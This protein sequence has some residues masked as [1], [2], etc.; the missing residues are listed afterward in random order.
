MSEDF[1]FLHHWYPVIPLTDLK[2][3]YPKS[4]TILGRKLVIW[5][6][7]LSPTFK[8][9]L[10]Q[11]P[12][13]LA[14]LSEGRIDEKTGQLMCSYHGWQFNENG[15]CTHIPQSDNRDLLNKNKDYYCA[16]ALPT[17]E[18][19]DLLWVWLDQHT[20]SLAEKTPLPVSESIDLEKGFVLTTFIREIAYDWSIL[21]ENIADPSHVPFAHHGVQ[22]KRD[23]AKPIKIDLPMVQPDLIIA[24]ITEGFPSKFIFQPPCRL[25]YDITF[26]SGKKAGVVLYCIPVLP[27]KSRVVAIVYRNFAQSLHRFTPRWW[28]HHK[29]RNP[30]LDGDMLILHQQELALQNQSLSWKDSYKLPTSA[31]T[32]IIEIR[33]WLDR[34]ALPHL[35]WEQWGVKVTPLRELSR[36]EL[37]DRYHQHTQHCSSC[38]QTL[39]NIQ[40][41]QK[42]LLIYFTV[43]LSIVALLP[44]IL[45][46]KIGIPLMSIAGLGLLLYSLL[47]LKLEPQFYVIDYRHPDKK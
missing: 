13:R 31:D 6:P 37:F 15:Q 46:T 42:I 44:D 20:V 30:V 41:T 1:N 4:L 17:Q 47:K 8:V 26:P 18:Y 24:E 12:H 29:T 7:K 10:D 43:T 28:D 16:T 40:L 2:E 33:R 9:F 27:H 14:P 38:N 25:E 19:Q 32:L 23:S 22:Q 11:C 36:E 21:I 45:R 39:Q 35:K 34:I 3:N 5:K